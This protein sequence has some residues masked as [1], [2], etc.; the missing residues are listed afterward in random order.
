[1]AKRDKEPSVKEQYANLDADTKR[2]LAQGERIVEV[3]KQD[4]SA[5]VPVEYQ[6]CILYAVTN[7]F[8]VD[9]AVEQIAEYEKELYADLESLHSADVLAPI[10]NTGSLS[11]ETVAALR[12][13]LEDFT[14]R[15]LKIHA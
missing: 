12:A 8:L 7:N 5:P 13:A 10:R 2:R 3:L 4:R 9:V 6:V 15:F 11:D 1:M 14:A